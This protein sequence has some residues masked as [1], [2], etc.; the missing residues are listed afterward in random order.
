MRIETRSAI[1]LLVTLALGAVLGMVGGG[2]IQRSREQQLGELRRPRG[3]VAHMEDVIQPRPEQQQAV[4]V[5]LD[6]IGQRN[7]RVIGAARAELRTGIDSMKL[8]LAPLLDAEQR[9]RLD[10]MSRLPDPFRPP[11]PRG[12]GPRG[13]PP[14][15]RGPPPP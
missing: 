9:D 13:G 15:G 4:R 8:R 12:D 6:S 3:F 5:I 7:D 14:P 10:R 2:L 1:I 11:P